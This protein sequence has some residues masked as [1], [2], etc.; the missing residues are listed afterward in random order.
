MQGE[1]YYATED[2]SLRLNRGGY[3]E[4]DGAWWCWPPRG[5][6]TLISVPVQQHPDGSITAAE[7]LQLPQWRGFLEHG[8]WREEPASDD[9][10]P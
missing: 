3:G 5:G 4:C 10:P 9:T 1:R 7:R 8:Y 6:V 2:G